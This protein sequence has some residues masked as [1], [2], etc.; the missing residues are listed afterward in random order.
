MTNNA[1]SVVVQA[2]LSDCMS[3]PPGVDY[4]VVDGSRLMQAIPSELLL[5]CYEGR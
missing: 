4:L 5:L 2:A 1:V 3:I